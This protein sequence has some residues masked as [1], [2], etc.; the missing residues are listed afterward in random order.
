MPHSYVVI[1]ETLKAI[2]DNRGAAFWTY[3]GMQR[4]PQNPELRALPQKL[5]QAAPVLRSNLK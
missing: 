4:Y 5:A 1:A 2:G 3:Q